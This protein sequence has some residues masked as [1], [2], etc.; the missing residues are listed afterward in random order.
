MTECIQAYTR[1]SA[2]TLGRSPLGAP[3]FLGRLSDI[4]IRKN[5]W[6][7]IRRASEFAD[8]HEAVTDR[9]HG[10]SVARLSGGTEQI[11]AVRLGAP[12]NSVP[13]RREDEAAF[14]QGLQRR[15]V[16]CPHGLDKL[17]LRQGPWPLLRRPAS[18]RVRGR[19]GRCA[20]LQQ[21]GARRRPSTIGRGP[22][23]GRTPEVGL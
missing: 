5:I 21:L 7:R 23:S 2:A 9:C 10:T 18:C 3:G 12:E 8:G 16:H 13:R 17:S 4:S 15:P 6:G 19:R 11:I 20:R 1:P 22:G 14:M